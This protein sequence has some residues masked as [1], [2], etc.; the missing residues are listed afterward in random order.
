MNLYNGK[1]KCVE[2]NFEATIENNTSVINKWLVK[3]GHNHTMEYN[4]AVKEDVEVLL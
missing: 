1:M 3:L 4:A 2:C